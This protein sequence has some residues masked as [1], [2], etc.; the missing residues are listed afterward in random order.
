M[1]LRAGVLV[2]FTVAAAAAAIMLP[3]HPQPLAY[4]RFADGRSL[5]GIPNFCDVSSNAFFLVGGAL[6]LWAATRAGTR[7]EARS[8]RAP[9]GL[10]FLGM[11]LTSAGSAYYHWAPD[12]ERLLWDRLPMMLAF[13]SLVAAQ[14]SD[15]LGRSVGLRALA[16]LLAVG[17]ASV[18]FWY[19]TERA[20][21]GNLTPY[22]VLQAWAVLG[23]A[24]LAALF[25]SR[26]THGGSVAWTFAAYALA[27]VTESYDEAIFAALGFVS[28][29]TL[30]HVLAA[31]AGGFVCQML[32][33]RHAR[34]TAPAG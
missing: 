24:L 16:P 1:R 8:E 4:H 12:N 29:H 11:L 31:L 3:A 18:L 10:F 19:A 22:A 9:Y 13:M 28:G 14:A 20:G 21:V 33:V 2:G 23:V 6:G 32:L 34:G 30:K 5:W 27:K 25:R 15:R 17:A 26:Y 7:F